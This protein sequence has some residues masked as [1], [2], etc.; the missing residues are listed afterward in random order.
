M[1][2]ENYLLKYVLQRTNKKIIW[3]TLIDII[4]IIAY[5]LSDRQFHFVF[6]VLH[7]TRILALQSVMVLRSLLNVAAAACLLK[8]M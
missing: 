5:S 8:F 1:P 3:T 6:E 7:F 4:Y 2:L